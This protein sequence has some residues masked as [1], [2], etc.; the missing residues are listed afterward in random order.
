MWDLCTPLSGKSWGQATQIMKSGILG[1]LRTPNVG[2]TEI[3]GTPPTDT[4][5]L[6]KEK[7]NYIHKKVKIFSRN[8][9]E[10]ADTEEFLLRSRAV[11]RSQK[12]GWSTSPFMPLV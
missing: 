11:E 4:K 3:E 12:D 6:T 5:R 9:S 1:M 10:A 8:T 2:A 7:K